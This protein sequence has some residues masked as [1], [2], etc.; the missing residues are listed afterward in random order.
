MKG[1]MEVRASRLEKD[2][3][4]TVQIEK[5]RN[6]MDESLQAL[7]NAIATDSH[8]SA[9]KAEARYT[10]ASLKLQ[11][12]NQKVQDSLDCS[13]PWIRLQGK[14]SPFPRKG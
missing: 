6:K 2:Y 9:V 14:P 4:R 3:A 7:M 11:A 5:L 13:A 8:R 1:S 12:V 10:K